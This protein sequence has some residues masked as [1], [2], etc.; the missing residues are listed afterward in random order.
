MTLRDVGLV[1]LGVP[2]GY[3]L[4][5]AMGIARYRA[6]VRRLDEAMASRRS[7]ERDR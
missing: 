5:V 4:H 2:L 7:E 3:V 6:Y 1:L